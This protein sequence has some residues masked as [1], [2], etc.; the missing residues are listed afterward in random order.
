MIKFIIDIYFVHIKISFT[1]NKSD[2]MDNEMAS[3]VE[4]LNGRLFKSHCE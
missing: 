2:C 3:L 1:W 4:D